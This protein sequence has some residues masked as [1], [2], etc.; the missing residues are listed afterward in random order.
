MVEDVMKFG[1]SVAGIQGNGD[2]S[3]FVD[4]HISAEIIDALGIAEHQTDA[5]VGPNT[6]GH[7]IPSNGVCPVFPFQEGHLVMAVDHDS[8]A[9]RISLDLSTQ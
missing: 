2:R 6:L 4:T 9:F 1:G 5:I 8:R 7:Q 3:C